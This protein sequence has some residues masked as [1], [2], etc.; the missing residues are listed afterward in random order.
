MFLA[1]SKSV[2]EAKNFAGK[3]AGPL[4]FNWA[5]HCSLFF[6]DEEFFSASSIEVVESS[7]LAEGID[8]NPELCCDSGTVGVLLESC[9]P[10]V[11]LLKGVS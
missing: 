2:K 4:F 9:I 5:V 11:V 10:A 3:D 1:F 8:A 6:N 7:K